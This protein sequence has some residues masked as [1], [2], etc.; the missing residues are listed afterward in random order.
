MLSAL[1]IGFVGYLTGRVDAVRD[2]LGAWT[3]DQKVFVTILTGVAGYFA[4]Y[5]APTDSPEDRARTE[6]FYRRMRTPV[7]FEREVGSR[8]GERSQAWIL[9]WVSLATG[10]AVSL[11]VFPTDDWAWNGKSGVLAIAGF[12]MLIG[13]VLLWA[14]RRRPASAA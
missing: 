11:L 1:A 7:D 2:L 12:Q 10:A 13:S 4:V 14:G 9:G 6:E 3:Y 8:P 5:L